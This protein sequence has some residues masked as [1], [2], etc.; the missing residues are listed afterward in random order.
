MWT[1]HIKSQTGQKGQL[2][3][4]HPAITTKGLIPMSRLS[5]K[6]REREF[7][8]LT[9][10]LLD[11]EPVRMMGRWKHHGPV[12]TLDHS[13]FV[14]F[15]TY[16]VARLL[17]LD[18]RSAVRGAL[19]HDLYLY[20]SHDKTAHPGNQCF[21]HPRFAARNA[22]TLTPLTPKERNIIL[23]H[24]WPLGGALPRSLEAWMVDLVD[25]I[26]AGL[27][28]SRICR[29]SRLRERLGVRPL[30]PVCQ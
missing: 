6:L 2:R 10:E 28:M 18:V 17:R 7:V 24:M 20:D 26:C 12:T 22:A 30:V 9:R 4:E 29:P 1:E 5:R 13:L 27:E 8:E 16:R 15:S 3:G 11:S 19:L 25:T 23:S 14:A 21:D